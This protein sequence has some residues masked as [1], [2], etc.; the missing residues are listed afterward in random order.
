M[1]LLQ[2]QAVLAATR[3]VVTN[4]RS[5]QPTLSDNLLLAPC[6]LDILPLL[7]IAAR[8]YSTFAE[9][10]SRESPRPAI[11]LYH[12]GTWETPADDDMQRLLHPAWFVPPTMNLKQAARHYR[13]QVCISMVGAHRTRQLTSDLEHRFERVLYL[14]HLSTEPS[15]IGGEPSD[16]VA[17]DEML[18]QQ[19]EASAPAGGETRGMWD[20]LLAES[21]APD[22]EPFVA[23]GPAIEMGIWGNGT[24]ETY[25]GPSVRRGRR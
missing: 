6:N 12:D 4:D 11:T 1:P 19:I 13:P 24:G 21:E 18:R 23:F 5:E 7:A 16:F 20:S 2:Q 15:T 10:E 25:P 17:A 22:L 14:Q 3:A 8:D 9:P